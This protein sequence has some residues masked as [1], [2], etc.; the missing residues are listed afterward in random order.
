MKKIFATAAAVTALMT[1]AAFA[2]NVSIVEQWGAGNGQ[3]TMQSG[4]NFAGTAQAGI[5]NGSFTG[6]NGTGN[7]AG[8]LQVGGWNSSVTTQG[9]HFNG[10]GTAQYGSGHYSNTNQVGLGNGSM[11]IQTDGVSPHN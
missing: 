5:A 1:G 8:T 11:T 3:L 4:A 9:G 10:A 6:Q 7:A 2:Q